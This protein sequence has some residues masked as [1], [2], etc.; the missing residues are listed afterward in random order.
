ME[1]HVF[2]QVGWVQEWG[3]VATPFNINFALLAV[4]LLFIFIFE[5]RKKNTPRGI[6]LPCLFLMA[7]VL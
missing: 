2:T 4:R 6:R 5:V 1:K 3:R 7:L